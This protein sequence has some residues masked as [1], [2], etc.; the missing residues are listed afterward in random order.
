MDELALLLLHY[1]NAGERVQDLFSCDFASV[2]KKASTFPS[3]KFYFKGFVVNIS[4]SSL[5]LSKIS[6]SKRFLFFQKFQQSKTH[7]YI[8]FNFPQ[9]N[10]YHQ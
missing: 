4:F 6:N 5:K 9:T 10:N 2:D 7:R 3:L 8:K 1:A